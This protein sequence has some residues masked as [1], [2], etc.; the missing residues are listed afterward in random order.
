MGLLYAGS[1]AGCDAPFPSCLAP[2]VAVA[3]DRFR[4]DSARS[5]EPVNSGENGARVLQRHTDGRPVADVRGHDV[6][7]KVLEVSGTRGVARDHPN[8][9]AAVDQPPDDERAEAT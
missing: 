3:I 4:R 8:V 9:N 6:Y 2:A 5:G 1:R 7:R